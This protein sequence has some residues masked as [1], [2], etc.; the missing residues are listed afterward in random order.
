ERQLV[1]AAA[2]QSKGAAGGAGS[3]APPNTPAPPNAQPV[4]EAQAAPGP[5]LAVIRLNLQVEARFVEHLLFNQALEETP[6]FLSTDAL[7][8]VAAGQGASENIS[9]LVQEGKVGL[10]AQLLT[11]SPPLDG[12][13]QIN[14]FFKADKAGPTTETMQF[15]EQAGRSDP[16]VMNGV[17]EFIRMLN[18]HYSKQERQPPGSAP[19]PAHTL[20]PNPAQGSGQMG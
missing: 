16:F 20:P 11:A 13:Y 1:T 7:S 15:A 8:L 17:D 6:L 3:Q 12:K 10:A 9:K 14:L 18:E 2:Q 4:P 5:T 19:Q